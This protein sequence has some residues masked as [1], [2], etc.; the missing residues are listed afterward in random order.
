MRW[1]C[2][3]REEITH[4]GALALSSEIGFMLG[5]EVHVVFVLFPP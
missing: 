5:A 2:L 3:N 4:L 1:R